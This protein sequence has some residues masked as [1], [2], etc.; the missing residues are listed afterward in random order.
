MLRKL[1]KILIPALFIG[2]STLAA[3]ASNEA[4]R[5][6]TTTF[7]ADGLEKIHIDLAFG[8][9]TVEGHDGTTVEVDLSLFCRRQDADTCRKRAE[10]VQVRPRLG[11]KRLQISLD[12]TMGGQ[13][14]GIDAIA[15]I[16]VPKRHMVELDLTRGKA[17][18]RNLEGHLEVDSTAGTIDITYPQT[19]VAKIKI[20][21]GAGMGE[22]ILPDGGKVA[23]SGWPRS[24]KWLGSGGAEID[25]DGG[26]ALVTV[27]LR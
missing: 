18:I 10:N 4:V 13:L 24:I 25:V 15:V 8:D 26:T 17:W 14:G 22:L 16:R 6:F 3:Q 2:A 20:G 12:N 5:R 27:N 19:L 21:L 23:S 7:A 1:T 9:V 11:K